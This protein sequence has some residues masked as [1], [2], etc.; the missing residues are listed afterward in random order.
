MVNGKLEVVAQ[1][2]LHDA[3]PQR[4]GQ[5]MPSPPTSRLRYS[6]VVARCLN[7]VDFITPV[8]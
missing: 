1:A 6:V 4:R 5:L 8:S 3:S 2:K 7:Y